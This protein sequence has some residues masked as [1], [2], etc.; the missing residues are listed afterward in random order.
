MAYTYGLSAIAIAAIAGDGGPGTT[1]ATIGKTNPGTTKIT[2]D[3]GTTSEKRCEELSAPLV[4]IAGDETQTIEF[5]LIV[6]GAAT[7]ESVLGGTV[8]TGV[9]SAP[10]TKPVIEKTLKI[11]PLSG[12]TLQFN[13]VSIDAALNATLSREG[14]LFY[15]DCVCTV[16]QP[17][18]ANT[19]K[20]TASE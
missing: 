13:R 14:D 9:W 4:S 12:M 11:T 10:D 17:T 20:A 1:F 6:E 15:V 8:A 16:L 18:K 19:P 5:Q 7:L 2:T 3:K